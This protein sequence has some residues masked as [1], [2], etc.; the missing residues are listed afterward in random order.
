MQAPKLTKLVVIEALNSNGEP[1]CTSLA[2]REK[3]LVGKGVGIGLA[4]E[5]IHPRGSP[6]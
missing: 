5:L 1:R 6:S 3:D 4:G 2:N